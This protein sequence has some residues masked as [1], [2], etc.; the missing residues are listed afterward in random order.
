MAEHEHERLVAAMFRA[1][2]ARDL[3]SA[4]ALWADDCVDHTAIP[5][6]PPGKDGILATLAFVDA[7][8]PGA[9][10]R[11]GR[12]VADADAVACR[13]VAEG[14]HRAR[15]MEYRPPAAGCAGSTFITSGSPRG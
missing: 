14:E 3:D 4:L 13:V 6:A 12:T 10:W 5:D 11:L 8:F 9:R 15:S 1:L 7:A 2:E